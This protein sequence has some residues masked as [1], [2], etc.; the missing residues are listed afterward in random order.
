MRAEL[1]RLKRDTDS[2]RSRAAVMEPG[3][4]V[5]SDGKPVAET[6]FIPVTNPAVS[7]SAASALATPASGTVAAGSSS[8]SVAA[9]EPARRKSWAVVGAVLALVLAT[10]AAGY[11]FLHRTPSAIDSVA[12]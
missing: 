1:Q 3:T 12:V 8:S 10:A 6:S 5:S 11:Y 7:G 4:L 2:S 9:A